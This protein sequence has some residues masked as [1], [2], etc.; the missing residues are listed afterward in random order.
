[1]V[2]AGA[3]S[4]AATSL[5]A[6][7]M[8][9]AKRCIVLAAPRL[10]PLVRRTFPLADVRPAGEDDAAAYAE[11]DAVATAA[12]LIAYFW[13]DANSAESSFL[14]LRADAA[15][16]REFRAK[17]RGT[18]AKPLVGIAWSSAAYA[19]DLPPLIEWTRLLRSVDATFVS[20]Q[21]GRADADLARLR[22]GH[23]IKL[24]HDASVDQLVDMD[25]FAAQIAALDAV[26]TISNTGAHLASALG[27]PCIILV[28]DRF[29]RIWPVVG[30]S[31]PWYPQVTLIAK[32]GRE[33]PAVMD[34]AKMRLLTALPA[35]NAVDIGR[36]W[37]PGHE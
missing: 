12:H 4:L 24:I 7:A 23:P 5:I 16:V 20:L 21:Y 1:M 10:V 25:R 19:K 14:P 34:E 6:R 9:R 22:A 29:R 26:V 2:E 13:T 27:M 32:K 36:R 30:D 35:A 31:A 15:L 17:Y 3:Q 8:P 37:R 28:D 18:Q 11:S 33:W